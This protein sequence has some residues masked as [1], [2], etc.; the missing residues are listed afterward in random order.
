MQQQGL[1]K[2]IDGLYRYIMST[3]LQ[4]Y[5]ISFIIFSE[6]GLEHTHLDLSANYV[7]LEPFTL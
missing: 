1:P 2:T 4:Y 7:S 3:R 6:S 5:Y